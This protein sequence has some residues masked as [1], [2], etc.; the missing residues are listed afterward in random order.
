MSITSPIVCRDAAA[1]APQVTAMPILSSSLASSTPVTISGVNYIDRAYTA[2]YSQYTLAQD[3][4]AFGV[5]WVVTSDTPAICTVTGNTV[6][7]LADGFG[8]IRFT[9]P[10][11][12]S[13]VKTIQ[14]NATALP[15]TRI[16]TG[17]QAGSPSALFSDPLLA[18]T[19]PTKQLNYYS[20]GVGSSTG[21]MVRNPNCWLASLDLSAS[22]VATSF[23]GAFGAA[24][25][26]VHLTRRHGFGAKHWGTEQANMGPGSVLT[27]AGADGIKHNRTVLARYVHPTY[28]LICWL[29]D[30]DLPAGVNPLP[31]APTSHQEGTS[32]RAYG[33]GFQMT[34]EKNVSIIAYDDF[35]DKSGSIGGPAGWE[36]TFD[37]KTDPAHR[38]YGLGNLMQLGRGGDSG[39]MICGLVGS[40]IFAISLFIGSKHGFY[41]P[42]FKT[43]LNAMI[44]SVDAAAGVPTGYTVSTLNLT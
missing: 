42:K 2:G 28:D 13:R 11:G 10:N 18:L 6:T 20:S 29:L 41:L 15:V 33:L 14:F 1:Y 21:V 26:G 27:F 17:V 5:P 37:L 31:L 23:G 43:E 40:Q 39:G 4:P 12:F 38:L 9:G 8:K 16:W 30:S 25:S 3:L 35:W 24:N 19:S 44:A 36:S 7:R 32:A 22:P 34:Q